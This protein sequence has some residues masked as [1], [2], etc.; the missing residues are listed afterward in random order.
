MWINKAN[1][2]N[3]VC[4]YL[5]CALFLLLDFLSYTIGTLVTLIIISVALVQRQQYIERDTFAGFALRYVDSWT[6]I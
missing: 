2:L 6:A 1:Q 4:I 5:Q 3:F